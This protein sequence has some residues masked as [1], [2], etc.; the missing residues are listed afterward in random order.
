MKGLLKNLT[1][2][3]EQEVLTASRDVWH[4]RPSCAVPR[5]RI[6]HKSRFNFQVTE[7][8]KDL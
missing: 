2:T 4:L 8:E 5:L 6:R 3:L 7:T 1:A